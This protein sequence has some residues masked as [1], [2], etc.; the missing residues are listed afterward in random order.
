MRKRIIKIIALLLGLITVL[1]I[2][3]VVYVRIA[4]RTEPPV[5]ASLAS[6]E[7]AV[8]EIDTGLFVVGNNWFRQSESGLYELYVE[9]APFERGVANGK[10]TH[11]SGAISGRGVQ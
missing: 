9:G 2:C 3:L 11:D 1:I 7:E 8:T 5:P 4:A 10:L 6:L